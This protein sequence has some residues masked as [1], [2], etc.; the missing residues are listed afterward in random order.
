MV[1]TILSIALRGDLSDTGY[2]SG[3]QM[4]TGRSHQS[5]SG[6]RHRSSSGPV[7]PSSRNGGCSGILL[8]A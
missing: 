6:G 2:L 5:V 8:V 4:W 3:R 1:A 7:I